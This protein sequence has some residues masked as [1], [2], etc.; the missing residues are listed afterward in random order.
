MSKKV[1]VIGGSVFTGRIYAIQM[2]K[3]DDIELHVV[4]RGNFQLNLKGV[5]EYKCDRHSPRMIAHLIPE[6]PYDAIIDFCAYNSGEAS[7]LLEALQGRFKHYIIFSS[8][9]VYEPYGNQVK[10]EGDPLVTAVGGDRVSDYIYNK[11]LLEKE[12]AATCKKLGV[13]YTILRSTFIYGPFNYSGRESYFVELIARGHVIPVPTDATARF[14]MVYAFDIAR[15]L[16][17]I[18]GN[19]KAFNQIFNMSAPEE[20][21]Y[22]LLLEAFEKFNGGPLMTR[23]VTVD[24][25]LAENIPLPFPMTEDELFSGEKFSETFDF[26]YT[27]FMEGMEKTYKIFYSLFIS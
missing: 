13:P 24:D 26:T 23:P 25:V 22:S 27:P 3:K 1:L 7:S 8:A 15:A 17:I 20:V 10:K 2:S 11:I 14:N 21:T 18:I 4:N 9:A 19:E 6:G 16:E 5:K 12:T